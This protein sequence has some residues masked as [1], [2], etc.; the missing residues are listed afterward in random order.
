[1]TTT[2]IEVL[3]SY[4][5][6]LRRQGKPLLSP[7]LNWTILS[8][9]GA[10][11]HDCVI[12]FIFEENQSQPTLIVKVP[13]LPE[14]ERALQVE[15]D[16]MVEMWE[17]LG[18]EAVFRMPEPIAMVNLEAQPALVKS[19]IHGESLLRVSKQRLWEKPEQVFLLAVDVAESLR[20]MMDRTATELADSEHIPTD[21]MQKIAKF[22]E[23]YRFTE[24]ED[25]A[26]LRLIKHIESIRN[27]ATH[28]VLI[29]GDF[30]HGNII[31]NLTHGKLMVIDRQYSRWST[32][33]SLDVY[34]FLLAGA[35]ANVPQLSVEERARGAMEVLL[36]WR[37]K[38]IPAYLQA[39]GKPSHYT[40]MP[41]RYGMLLC[42]VE[43][44]VRASMDLGVDQVNDL[45]W[46]YLFAEL[47]NL[48]D[49]SGFYDEI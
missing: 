9:G 31:R 37:P 25:Q 23:M 40:L 20:D 1:M 17:H 13:R 10:D 29:H 12:F 21:I 2:F 4:M 15:Y 16:R 34:L 22:K 18:P 47:V 19:Y 46:R 39:F 28:K 48:S 44:A 49:K 33:V 35:L 36:Q 11:I 41:A 14:D 7:P 8:N 3:I 45:I 42:C 27:T 32:D 24:L 26:I 5:I 43:K 6:S 30:W 38:I